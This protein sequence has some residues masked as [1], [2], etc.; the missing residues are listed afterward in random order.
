MPSSS[1]KLIFYVV[2]LLGVIPAAW[3]G[4]AEDVAAVGQQTIGAFEKGDIDTF[5]AGWADNAVFTPSVQAFRVE[6][7]A[8]HSSRPIRRATLS[9]DRAPREPMRT[10]LS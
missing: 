5:I 2:A 8:A 6:G 7:K 4:A 10:R 3:A 9:F 1:I